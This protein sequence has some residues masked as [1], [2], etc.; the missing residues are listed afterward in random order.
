MNEFEPHFDRN[1]LWMS[2]QQEESKTIKKQSFSLIGTL[3]VTKYNISCLCS[4]HMEDFKSLR[5][6]KEAVS[7]GTYCACALRLT[8]VQLFVYIKGT[9]S[10]LS[11]DYFINYTSFAKYS[12]WNSM[13]VNDKTVT[14][15]QPNVS[16]GRYKQ[17]W[18]TLKTVQPN[19]I[20]NCHIAIRFNLLHFWP[21][22]PS[23]VFAVLL[24]YFFIVSSSYIYILPNF[25]AIY[26]A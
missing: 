3:L 21:S 2:K 15:L 4:L 18:L 19:S 23:F 16:P 11:K 1:F 12:L 13:D 8:S 22:V 26:H 14:S 10:R 6:F 9:V 20:S 24:K 7:T 5:R 17:T 25:L